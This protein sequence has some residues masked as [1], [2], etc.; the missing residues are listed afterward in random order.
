MKVGY[1]CYIRNVSGHYLASSD[2]P[3]KSNSSLVWLKQEST[4]EDDICLWELVD[5][6][7]IKHAFTGYFI[8]PDSDMVDGESILR[9]K[10]LND[11]LSLAEYEFDGSHL[12]HKKS[13]CR[14][15]AAAGSLN[16]GSL[17]T[18]S[19]NTEDECEVI[20]MFGAVSQQSLLGISNND[21]Q[22]RIKC[23]DKG[24]LSI[25]FDKEPYLLAASE[26][27]IRFVICDLK[28][29]E[30]TW[31]SR[32][33]TVDGKIIN[34]STGYVLANCS[35]QVEDEEINLDDLDSLEN[36]DIEKLLLVKQQSQRSLLDNVADPKDSLQLVPSQNVKSQM[37]NFTNGHLISELDGAALSLLSDS[38]NR[39]ILYRESILDNP[40]LISWSFEAISSSK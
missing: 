22:Y 29:G 6:K 37:W 32:F 30:Y 35:P 2:H 11:D 27:P 3:P 12:M 14:V 17:A 38:S 19:L 9:L 18:I 24:F 23:K 40:S 15:H 16:S 21:V 31:Q 10:S 7:Y 13:K 20:L 5:G 36:V 25:D 28:D 33:K 26:D 4:I 34:V 1:N 39:V 8:V